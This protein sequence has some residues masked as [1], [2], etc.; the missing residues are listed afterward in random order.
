MKE[1]RNLTGKPKKDKKVAITNKH[2]TDTRPTKN[3]KRQKRKVNQTNPTVNNT[4]TELTTSISDNYQGKV[5]GIIAYIKTLPQEIQTLLNNSSL[6]RVTARQGF[7]MY[8]LENG[9]TIKIKDETLGKKN[10]LR[11]VVS[12]K[13]KELFN[14]RI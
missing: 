10:Y 12:Q 8:V 14:K 3:K 2:I 5:D 6:K 11:I 9:F 4:I 13:R 7:S 1:F